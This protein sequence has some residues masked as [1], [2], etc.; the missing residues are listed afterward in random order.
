MTQ[1]L[2]TSELLEQMANESLADPATDRITIGEFVDKLAERGFGIAI[3][4]CAIPNLF[5]VTI[6]GVSTIF[7]VVIGLLT[8]QWMSGMRHPWIPEFIRRK[9]FDEKKFAEGLKSILPR[10]RKMEQYIKPR[11]EWMTER[12]GTIIA[13]VCILIQCGVLVLPLPVI[14]FSNAIPAFFIALMA[15]GILARDGYILLGAMI[16]GTIAIYFLAV[17]LL[18]VLGQIWQWL[19]VHL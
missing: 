16:T 2:T 5:P 18:A 19:Q 17:A 8:L 9:S 12:T 6:P 14:P 1:I 4:L 10:I 11:G 13:G 15:I 3:L 7:S